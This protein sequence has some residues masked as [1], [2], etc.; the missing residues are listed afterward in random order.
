M[1]WAANYNVDAEQPATPVAPSPDS[2]EK[3]GNQLVIMF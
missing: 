1:E 3:A 2:P